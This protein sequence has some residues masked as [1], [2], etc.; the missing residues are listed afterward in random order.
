MPKDLMARFRDPK[1]G[2]ISWQPATR[3]AV[4]KKSGF[5]YRWISDDPE[6]MRRQ[7]E[8]GWTP[9]DGTGSPMVD[10][11]ADDENT[12]S[13]GGAKQY[14]ELV[15]HAMPDELAAARKRYFE[16]QTTKQTAGLKNRLQEELEDNYSGE[17]KGSPA[18]GKI[19]IE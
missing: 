13:L 19:V 5:T 3:L 11:D 14:R 6:N 9:V 15:L 17:G 8:E 4:K 10:F 12:D 18:Q 2:K 1:T 7:Q 16:E